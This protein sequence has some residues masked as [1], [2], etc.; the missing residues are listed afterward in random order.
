MGTVALEA[1][2]GLQLAKNIACQRKGDDG[3][4][5]EKIQ[6]FIQILKLIEHKIHTP[7]G[8]G[9][10]LGLQRKHTE[11]IFDRIALCTYPAHCDDLTRSAVQKCILIY[12]MFYQTFKQNWCLKNIYA[13]HFKSYPGAEFN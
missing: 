4:L 10:T 7:L 6:K 13:L 5:P 3:L 11:V 8:K 9:S 12:I 2:M 1:E